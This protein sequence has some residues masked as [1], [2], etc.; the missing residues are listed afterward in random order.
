[1]CLHACATQNARSTL[2]NAIR[3]V[4]AHPDWQARVVYGDTDSL[5]VLV[6]GQSRATAFKIG[7]EIAR[8]VTAVLW[9]SPLG[10]ASLIAAALCRSC[11]LAAT[12]AALALW[13]LVVSLLL[14]APLPPASAGLLKSPCAVHGFTVGQSAPPA[15]S[16]AWRCCSGCVGTERMQ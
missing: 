11:Q 15:A 2:E 4:E 7:A 10:V 5:F 13:V 12:A 9:T 8:M 1:M 3:M 16:H 14:S 6:P